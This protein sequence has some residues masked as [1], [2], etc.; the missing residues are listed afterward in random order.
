MDQGALPEGFE[1]LAPFV[2]DWVFDDASA[3]MAK[4]QASSMADIRRFYDAIV[5]LGV[6]AL[7]Y[8]REHKLGELPPEAEN[9]LKLMLSLAEIGPAVEWFDNPAV[10]DGFPIGRIRY[11]RHIPDVAAQW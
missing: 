6:E 1:A 7:D 10:Y 11:V 8:L 5:P 2:A 4:R 9:L 3:R